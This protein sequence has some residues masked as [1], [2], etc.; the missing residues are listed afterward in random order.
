MTEFIPR[1]YKL[2]NRIQNYEWGTRG[3]EAFIPKFLGREAEPDV[4]Y[5]ELWIGTHP[6]AS[7]E[8]ELDGRLVSL[9]KVI[10]QH[11]RESLG[12][13]VFSKFSGRLPFLLK[14]LSAARALSIQTHPDK[15]QAV[16][17]HA[18][19]PEQYPDD[20]HKPEM[21][22]AL[23]GLTA[24]VGFKPAGKISETLRSVP[25][26][27]E[28]ADDQVYSRVVSGGDGPG[29]EDAVK[30]LYADIMRKG[31]RKEELSSCIGKIRERLS[32]KQ[33]PSA[34]D[35]Q[36]L[37]QYELYGDDIGLFSFFF[38]NLVQLKQG[39]AIF[40]RAGM[41]HTYIEGNIIECMANSDNVVRAG[42]THKY[43]D[44]ETLL[45]IVKYEFAACEI[46]NAEHKQ[47]EVVYDAGVEEF[48]LT[49]VHKGGGFKR[50]CRSSDRP[51]V[52][53]VTGGEAEVVWSFA[54]VDHLE[55][56]SKGDSFFV[57]AFLSEFRISSE[58]GVDYFT[59]EIP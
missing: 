22:I 42:L 30:K 2:F 27:G 29:L 26:F 47:D 19:Q 46:M 33:S 50:A 57:P 8:I 55:S 1:P 5:A 41:P 39:Q 20:N 11:P 34:E 25:E 31:D 21:A 54:G 49:R 9:N 38:F 18:S 13:F 58:S 24:L 32:R 37:R 7:S 52:Y 35:L 12:E 36:F 44:V 17:L 40:T 45:N 14:V 16:R 56:F 15:E 3:G 28:F 43:K 53:L 10:E 4:P 51:S 48:R 6:K 23:D 59:V